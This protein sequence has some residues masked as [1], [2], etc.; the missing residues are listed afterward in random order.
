MEVAHIGYTSTRLTHRCIASARV[1]TAHGLTC[2]CQYF[3]RYCDNNLHTT[4]IAGLTLIRLMPTSPSARRRIPCS[5]L[6]KWTVRKVRRESVVN[7]IR[8]D[9]SPPR[10]VYGTKMAKHR[11]GGNVIHVK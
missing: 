4:A 6:L 11:M 5:E 10:A 9:S 8:G 7:T 1:P 2:L 3:I